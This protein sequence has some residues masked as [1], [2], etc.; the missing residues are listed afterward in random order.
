MHAPR[1]WATVLTAAWL[2]GCSLYTAGSSTR[3]SLW[4]G[5]LKRQYRVYVPTGYQQ[6]TAAPL[7]FMLHGGFGTGGHL[8][9][10]MAAMDDQADRTGTLVVYPDGVLRAWNSGGCCGAPARFG[11]DDVGFIMAAL[12]DVTQRVSVDRTRVY[13]SGMS[14]GAMMS[15]ALACAHPEVFSAIAPVAG[16]LMVDCNPSQPVSVMHIH[17][18]EDKH[19]PWGGGVG[20]GPSRSDFFGVE[21]SVNRMAELASCGSGA[22]VVFDSDGVTCSRRVGCDAATEVMLCRVEGGGHDWPGG[23]PTNGVVRGICPQ[24][25][26]QNTSWNASEHIMDFVLA[27]HR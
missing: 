4:H 1:W 8:E 21:Q 15:Y 11:V 16:S 10:G 6:G 14:N 12:E 9:T 5:G 19:V 23:S 20:C 17:G 24:D 25:G 3:V 22:E 26:D 7:L 13:A 2:G 27:H 18:S